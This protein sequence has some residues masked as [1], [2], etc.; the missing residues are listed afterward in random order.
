MAIRTPSVL[1][2][3]R[4]LTGVP[5]RQKGVRILS[6]RPDG[7]G[8]VLL[9]RFE[10]SRRW[11]SR[12]IPPVIERRFELDELG[13]FVFRLVDGKADVAAII[14]AFSRRY[15]VSRR[16]AEASTVAF[17]KMLAQRNIVAIMIP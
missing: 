6:E 8:I 5:V 3:R 10:R 14:E 17:L 1:D 13:A 16:E 9:N 12:L 11:F 15:Q 7:D 4:S 2:R